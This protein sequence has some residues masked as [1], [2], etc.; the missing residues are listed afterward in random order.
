MGS[1]LLN[2]AEL[3]GNSPFCRTIREQVPFWASSDL[4]ILI[5][6]PTGTGKDVIARMIHAA[7]ERADKTYLSMNCATLG[8]EFIESSIL[9][10]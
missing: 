8:Q 6:G 9:F 5:I 1:K 4:P 2:S 7:S 10:H 3:I